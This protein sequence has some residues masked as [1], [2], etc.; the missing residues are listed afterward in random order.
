MAMRPS[1]HPR[2]QCDNTARNANNTGANENN[3]IYNATTPTGV[4]TNDMAPPTST[5]GVTNIEKQQWGNN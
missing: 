5:D 3:N 1:Y 4:A 2:Q